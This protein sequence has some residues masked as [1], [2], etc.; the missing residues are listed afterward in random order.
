[1]FASVYGDW[2]FEE[3]NEPNSLFFPPFNAIPGGRFN[4][5]TDGGGSSPQI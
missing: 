3:F 4:E 5:R 1:M 2:V